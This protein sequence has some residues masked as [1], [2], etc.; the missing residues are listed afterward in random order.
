M[1]VIKEKSNWIIVLTI[2]LIITCLILFIGSKTFNLQKEI[3]LS[4]IYAL[5]L[6]ATRSTS[7]KEINLIELLNYKVQGPA[8]SIPTLYLDLKFSNY[9]KILSDRENALKTNVLVNPQEVKG[10]LTLRDETFDVKIRLKGDLG[11]H[12]DIPHRMSYR[13][14][15]QDG[16]YIEGMKKFSLHKP[17]ARQV[18]FDPAFQKLIQSSG[19]LSSSHKYFKLIVNGINYGVMHAEESLS[20]SFIEKKKRKDSLLFKLSN[21]DRFLYSSMAGNQTYH[22]YRLSHPAISLKMYDPKKDSSSQDRRKLLSYVAKLNQ[23]NNIS[24]LYDHS[25]FAEVLNYALMW[26]NSHTLYPSNTKYYFNPYTL[27]VEPISSDQGPIKDLLKIDFFL[28][29]HF[30]YQNL[31]SSNDY[32]KV[33]NIVKEKILNMPDQAVQ[34]LKK[35]LEFFP[36]ETTPD[37]SL[38]FQ[39][40]NYLK[41]N[42]EEA[43][44]SMYLKNI[45]PQ[46]KNI[47]KEQAS[48][49]LRHLEGL[50]FSDGSLRIYNLLPVAVELIEIFSEDGQTLKI[51]RTIPGF[52]NSNIFK[53]LT[54]ATSF[55]GLHDNKLF[56][57]SKFMDEVK[58]TRL[59]QSLLK[60]NI[61]N[62]LQNP[63]PQDFLFL[64]TYDDK[65][66]IKK[67]TWYVEKPM[68]ID[69]KLEINP[70]AEISFSEDAF[71]VVNG[72]IQAIGK[73]DS[74]IIF[75]ANKNSWKGMYI[76]GNDFD[77]QKSLLEHVEI[78]NTSGVSSGLLNLTGGVSFYNSDLEMRNIKI[79]NTK[80][81]DALNI[82]K[83]RIK[84]EGL[85]IN[86][87]SSDAI[88]FDFSEGQMSN[89]NFDKIGG[90]GL[91]FSGSK[92]NLDNIFLN[93]VADKSISIGEDS[94]ISGR[95][96]SANNVGVGIV[97]KDGSLGI[98]HECKIENFSLKAA[99]S[100]VKKQFYN[101]PE[102]RLFDCNISLENDV[103][104]QTGSQLWLNETLA[105]TQDLDI[106]KLYSEGIMKK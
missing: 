21:E 20:T 60:D 98:F 74:K 78:Y 79:E 12:W 72:S 40:S 38:L 75:K 51:N 10:T 95:R 47:T 2:T 65:Y 89:S 45:E 91:D 26:G 53:P 35:E 8:H 1:L 104:S 22:P 83:S 32:I 61:V 23:E 14:K 69:G 11:Q 34:F 54:V 106:V 81:E 66:I 50:H 44:A 25:K 4:H 94:N 55:R 101:S 29:D 77:D 5:D 58:I 56:L 103:I 15:V 24:D 80:A 92:V 64:E 28:E 68:I 62:P 27:R 93:N 9:Q 71:L 49:L 102:L 41:N 57:K 84:I 42:Y 88:D 63:N 13:I 7:L 90:D 52:S 67:G 3:L 96:I 6:G 19:G 48:F 70:G 59:G 100:Y 99:M 17:S 82:I 18:P 97:V 30:I 46:I 76:N 39:N 37:Y 87:T 36:L 16:K 33:N 105:I 31:F 43:I 73:E 86:N 85:K